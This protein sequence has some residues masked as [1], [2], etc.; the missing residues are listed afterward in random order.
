[1]LGACS[2]NGAIPNRIGDTN[3]NCFYWGSGSAGGR[4]IQERRCCAGMQQHRLFCGGWPI[5]VQWSYSCKAGRERKM[6]RGEGGEG[7]E[8]P[9]PRSDVRFR[10]DQKTGNFK[11][12]MV[13]RVMQGR[14]F[15]EEKQ[16]NQLAHTE[17]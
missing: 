7:A 15:T 14:A 1:M 2:V 9:G 4:V 8:A 3:K 12:T 11:V 6:V 17:F 13:S 10:L 5:G 16:K